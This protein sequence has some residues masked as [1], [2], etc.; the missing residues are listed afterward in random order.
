MSQ[1]LHL[2]F[3]NTNLVLT[4]GSLSPQKKYKENIKE[5]S[6]Q[7]ECDT[8][9]FRQNINLFNSTSYPEGRWLSILGD[10]WDL[11]EDSLQQLALSWPC[12]GQGWIWDHQRP[13]PA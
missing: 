4:L 9:I 10:T 12:V 11:A 1:I 7:T 2:G 3:L 6:W 5:N 8:A 13:L